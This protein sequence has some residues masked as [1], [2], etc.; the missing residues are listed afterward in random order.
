MII[1]IICIFT[2]SVTAWMLFKSGYG[3]DEDY[4]CDRCQKMYKGAYYQVCIESVDLT[5]CPQCHS[6]LEA[7][8]WSLMGE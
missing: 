2:L 1:I 7:G 3:A 4:W 6:A 8:E 5:L